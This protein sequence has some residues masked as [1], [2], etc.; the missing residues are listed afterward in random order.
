[1]R[2]TYD[3]CRGAYNKLSDP[4]KQRIATTTNFNEIKK[5]DYTPPQYVV[6]Y[7]NETFGGPVFTIDSEERYL[8][9]MTTLERVYAW[10]PDSKEKGWDPFNEKE[11]GIHMHSAETPVDKIKKA[12]DP[13]HYQEFFY[14]DNPAEVGMQWLDAKS[15][16]RRFSNPDVFKGALELQIKKY[17]DRNGG[18]DEELQELL[19]ARWY[20]S[21]LCAYIKNGNKP[22]RVEDIKKI[23][24]E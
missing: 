20:L 4:L 15:R 17:L 9:W 11:T 8:A 21:Y 12:V 14:S 23:L 6:V 10:K 18:K 19:K 16:E 22:I 13:S 7:D 24:G 2:Y 3:T 5:E 1:M